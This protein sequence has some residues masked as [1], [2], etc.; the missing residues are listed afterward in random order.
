MKDFLEEFSVQ[1][2]VDKTKVSSV[3]RQL[4]GLCALSAVSQKWLERQGGSNPFL[5]LPLTFELS[6]DLVVASQDHEFRVQL[7]RD[8]DGKPSA[9]RSVNVGGLDLGLTDDPRQYVYQLGE[10]IWKKIEGPETL[11][12][13]FNDEHCRYL[14]TL[15]IDSD[16]GERVVRYAGQ[17]NICD[18]LN[19][20][21]VRDAF[22]RL[23]EG[24]RAVQF[25]V[26]VGQ[27]EFPTLLVPE[28]VLIGQIEL[29]I[30]MLDKH[31]TAS[32]S[33]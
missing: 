33:R 27:A 8:E 7:G 30:R 11:P 15:L 2:E 4:L 14:A 5:R 23:F 32:H 21:E 16:D 13:D 10:I 12:K 31:D 20:S 24:V 29:F 25:K 22:R 17:G 6:V 26:P 9:S 19:I 3:L 1:A 28:G 18:T